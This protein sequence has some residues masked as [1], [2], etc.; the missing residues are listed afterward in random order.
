MSSDSAVYIM[1]WCS[2]TEMRKYGDI[3]L[4]SFDINIERIAGILKEK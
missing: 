1:I 2:N 4:L 3:R